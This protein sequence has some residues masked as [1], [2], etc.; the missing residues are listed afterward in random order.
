MK[1]TGVLV[2]VLLCAATLA[3]CFRATGPCY[4]VGCRAFAPGSGSRT[5]NAAAPKQ[6]EKAAS[7]RAGAKGGQKSH[8]VYALLKKIKL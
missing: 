1:T 5:Q 4:G 7:A 6:K 8:G 3:G 2:V